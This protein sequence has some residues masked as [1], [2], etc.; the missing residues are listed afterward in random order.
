MSAF[1]LAME[2][3]RE[4]PRSAAL[5][6]SAAMVLEGGLLM[7]ELPEAEAARSRRS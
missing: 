1:A 3:I 5:Q 4:Y 7:S 6:Y 2:K